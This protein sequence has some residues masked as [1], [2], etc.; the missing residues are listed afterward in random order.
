MN[1]SVK[2]DD[3]LARYGGEEFVVLLPLT[4]L[5]N[6]KSAADNIRL[7]IAGNKLINNKNQK[8]LGHITVSIGVAACTKTDDCESIA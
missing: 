8:S 4:E 1:G 7:K 2:G 6:A 5:E 3:M